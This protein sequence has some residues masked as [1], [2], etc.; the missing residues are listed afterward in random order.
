MADTSEMKE[1]VQ[2]DLQAQENA[3]EPAPAKG[4]GSPKA[5]RPG[6]AFFL[7][8]C[9]TLV[10]GL[11]GAIFLALSYNTGYVSIVYGTKNSI[12]LTVLA[13]VIPA[14][15]LIL[16]L[17]QW[18][19]FLKSEHIYNLVS[20][21]LVI[22]LILAILLLLADRV[23]AIGNCIV[24]PWDAGH[25]GEDSCYLSFVSMGV[26]AVAMIGNIVLCFKGYGPKQAPVT[27]E[28]VSA[29]A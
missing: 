15:A 6:G 4:A 3:Q 27:A 21:A 7:I 1:A 26:W 29:K 18:K 16:V 25:G 9:A 28:E 2:A 11:I 23:D 10:L 14:A 24:A 22:A 8:D 5:K 19:G 13:I 17:G 12:T 20:Y